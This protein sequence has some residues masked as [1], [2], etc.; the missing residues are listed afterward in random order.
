MLWG[1]ERG[2]WGVE[3]VCEGAVWG[4]GGYME[5]LREMWGVRVLW[6]VWEFYEGPMGNLWR[7]CV[8]PVED[9]G[10]SLGGYG[11]LWGVVG[12]GELW[13]DLGSM[14]VLWGLGGV[15][16]GL[17]GV[18]GPVEELWGIMWSVCGSGGPY[19]PP[20]YILGAGGPYSPPW[21]PLGW[22]V[23]IGPMGCLGGP[24]GLG[25]LGVWGTWVVPLDSL[26]SS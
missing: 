23:P 12:W 2:L 26:S 14:G 7:S 1:V 25:V 16:V 10:G 18:V 8:G 3:G 5:R 22:G 17:R 6:G 13:W 21:V 4:C 20:W 11:G 19:N 15:C 9:L 24:V